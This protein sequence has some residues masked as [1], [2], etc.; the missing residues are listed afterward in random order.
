MS[1]DHQDRLNKNG[2][3]LVRN[4]VISEEFLTVLRRDHTISENTAEEIM[5]ERT[6]ANRVGKLLPE[7]KHKKTG[8]ERFIE[9]LVETE[10][11]SYADLLDAPLTD[12]FKRK[13][14]REKTGDA[15]GTKR[16]T[17]VDIVDLDMPET[18]NED[19]T[20]LI[21]SHSKLYS[22]VTHSSEQFIQQHLLRQDVYRMSAK[23]GVAIIINNMSFISHAPR[24]SAQSDYD[25]VGELFKHFKYQVFMDFNLDDSEMVEFLKKSRAELQTQ[26]IDVLVVVIMTHGTEN[27]VYGAN[28]Q[29]VDINPTI[30]SI[31]SDVEC[32]QLKG[33]P[34]LYFFQACQGNMESSGLQVGDALD[35]SMQTGLPMDDTTDDD[36]Q[37][38]DQVVGCYMEDD[39]SSFPDIMMGFASCT[40]YA[41]WKN[42]YGSWYIRALIYVLAHYAHKDDI[43]TMMTKVGNIV[44]ELRTNHP[45]QRIQQ[46]ETRDTLSDK[47][48]LLPRP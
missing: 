18:P 20:A 44:S 19:I 21:L 30:L 12:K 22:E 25:N 34:K 33:K 9:A 11:E 37:A 38:A 27:K 48:Y 47:L 5:F 41:A 3:V 32:P 46:P 16:R 15:R 42:E 31:F 39:I 14:E 13:K 26:P 28:S 4:V 7:L 29:P 10:Q 17:D 2:V 8:L 23:T 45:K 43:L 1:K 40:G 36:N 6:R 35:V 24:E